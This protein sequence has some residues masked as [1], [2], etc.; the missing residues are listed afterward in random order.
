M[1]LHASPI[2]TVQAVGQVRPTTASV[3]RPT[4]RIANIERLRVFGAIGIVWFHTDMA[5]YRDIGYAG[6]PIFL[7]VF[8]SLLTGQRHSDDLAHYLQRRWSLLL[9]PW[10]FWSLVYGLCRVAHATTEANTHSLDRILSLETVLVGTHV[11]LWYLPYAFLASL[12]IYALKTWTRDTHNLSAIVVG[13]GIGLLTLIV[14]SMPRFRPP[15]MLPLPQWEFGLPAIA[16]GFAIGKCLSIRAKAKRRLPLLVISLAT[17]I[18]CL[19]LTG[20]GY[21]SMAIP[22]LLGTLLVCLGYAWPCASD[23]IF[24]LLAP[25]TFG[26]YLIHPL[27]AHLLKY[28][29]PPSGHPAVFIAL[30]TCGSALITLTLMKTPIKKFL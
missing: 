7:L 13:T 15:T 18:T 20:L 30:T 22:Y 1:G 21:A 9:K 27:V 8:F 23:P 25:L 2:P 3:C 11:H 4:Q 26:V 16:L 29:A 17:L 12:L 24:S 10:L 6:L 5:P 28:V 14:C 19:I